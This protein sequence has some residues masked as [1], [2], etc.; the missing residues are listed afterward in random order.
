VGRVIGIAEIK[1]KTHQKGDQGVSWSKVDHLLKQG[2]SRKT[3]GSALGALTVRGKPG[4]IEKK[5]G[6]KL[7][8]RSIR[9]SNE[10]GS[11][12]TIAAEADGKRK[13]RK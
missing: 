1:Q 6:L 2:Y 7:S 13:V 8:L 3:A 11:A 10:N 12:K 5:A 9:L 4:D